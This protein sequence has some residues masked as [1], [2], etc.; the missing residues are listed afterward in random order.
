MQ[1]AGSAPATRAKAFRCCGSSTPPP[2]PPASPS[3]GAATRG[4]K[5]VADSTAVR[6][7]AH[8]PDPPSYHGP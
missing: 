4:A 3:R 5:L 8:I 6:Q 7:A 2:R 1:S